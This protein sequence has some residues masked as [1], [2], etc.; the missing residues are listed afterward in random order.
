MR[1]ILLAILS[2]A[3]L[4]PRH[5]HAQAVIRNGDI[6]ELT[7]SGMPVEYAAE[8]H[9]SLTAAEDGEIR[10][11]YIGGL[12]ATGLSTTQLARAIERKLVADKIFTNPTAVVSLQPQSRFVTVGGA[13]RAPQAV[14][15][16][17]D[18]TLSNAITRAGDFS[19][20]ANKKKIKV[21][22]EGK[23]S[24]YNITRSERDPTQNPK[25]LPADE[26]TVLE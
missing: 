10:L 5:S 21:T 7:L 18:M 2:L 20:F 11:P 3:L 14:P 9:L 12:K 8:Y 23:V 1:F 4:L 19:D 13:V 25:L 17:V 16:N 26:V 15:W 22:R 24:Y 6:F